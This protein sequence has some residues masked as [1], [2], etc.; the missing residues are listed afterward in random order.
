MAGWF[1]FAADCFYRCLLLWMV[2][3]R[4]TNREKE[5]Q[6]DTQ[7]AKRQ[8]IEKQEE[9][10]MIGWFNY[11]DGWFYRWLLLLIVG[12]S[13]RLF[14]LMVNSMDELLLCI[15]YS[16]DGYFYECRSTYKKSSSQ[17]CFLLRYLSLKNPAILLLKL[18][19]DMFQHTESFP[20]EKNRIG[21]FSLVMPT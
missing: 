12:F 9:R 17:L 11:M 20:L 18:F 15:G 13:R 1:N 5:G 21:L 14:L 10:M 19:L 2:G 8:T 16:M 4:Q 3:Q 6:I 7:T